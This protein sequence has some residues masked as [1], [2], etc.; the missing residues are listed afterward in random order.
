MDIVMMRRG[1][2][3]RARPLAFLANPLVASDVPLMYS[4]ASSP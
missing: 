3:L 1:T 2:L 4:I